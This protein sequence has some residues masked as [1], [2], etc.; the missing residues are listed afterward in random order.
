MTLSALIMGAA[1]LFAQETVATFTVAALN[2]DGLPRK[3]AT[4]DVNPDGKEAAGATAIGQKLVGMGYDVIAVSEDFDYNENLIAPLADTYDF[5]TWRGKL[6]PNALGIL[7]KSW[8]AD[9]DGLNL[10]WKK[11]LSA[12]NEAFSLWNDYNGYTDQGADGLI[13]KGF[14]YYTVNISGVEV[15]LYILHM[16]AETNPGDITAREGQMNQL[17]SAIKATDNKRPI[18]V[19][20]DTNCRYTRDKLKTNFIDPLNADARFTV[21]DAWVDTNYDGVYPQ[22]GGGSLM[23]DALGYQKGEVV[24]KLFFI[25][26]TESEY[27]LQL[28]SFMSDTSFKDANGE[29]LAD[30]YPVVGEFEVYNTSEVGEDVPPSDEELNGTTYYIRNVETGKFL[31]SGGWWGTHAMQGEYGLPIAVKQLPNGKYTLSTPISNGGIPNGHYISQGDPYMNSAAAEWTLVEKG[32]VVSFTY[33]NGGTKALTAYDP[34]PGYVTTANYNA[35]DKYQQWEMLTKEQLMAEMASATPAKPVNVTYLLRGANFDADDLE[36]KNSWNN[37]ISP[38]ASKMSYNLCDGTFNIEYGN[39]VAEVYVSSYSGTTTYETRWEINQTLTGLPNGRYKVTMQG[40]YRVKDHNQDLNATSDVFLIAR[41]GEKENKTQLC[42]VYQTKVSEAIGDQTSEGY[43]VPN[44]MQQA[45]FF[46]NKGLYQNEVEIEVMDGTLTVAVAKTATSKG[47]SV[48]TCFDNFQI[49][50]LQPSTVVPFAVTSANKWGTLIL[51][52]DAAVP[53]GMEVNTIDGA[54]EEGV[55]TLTGVDVIAA[56]TPYVVY[57]EEGI[58]TTFEGFAPESL[59]ATYSDGKYMTGVLTAE[60]VKPMAGSYILQNQQET[61]IGFYVVPET[62]KNKVW[63]Y[64]CY[65]DS[66]IQPSQDVKVFYLSEGD[67]T[68]IENVVSGQQPAGEALYDLS[69]RRVAKGQSGIYIVNGRK[70]VK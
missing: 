41:S 69:G 48:W 47:S 29:P 42:Q 40:F 45:T 52:F 4:V 49:Q 57:A 25:N 22:Y 63:Q 46:F 55:L 38:D 43:Y 35:S 37:T 66:S 7:F 61:G 14:R 65:L 19:M 8:R 39:P 12:S 70:L 50:Y 32:G 16:D 56:L 53:A 27:Q 34:T 20:G 59:E 11:G 9:T 64:H 24:D 51:P 28:K 18:I 68:A 10:F 23:V 17:V 1:C 30:H 67:A 60:G 15:D 26:N 31:K 3:I 6:N 5:G 21:H 33:Q 36:G 44:S 54:N 13:K 2:V 62:W 58:S